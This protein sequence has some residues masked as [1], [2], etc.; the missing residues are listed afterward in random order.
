MQ[1]C[2][3][4]THWGC[5]KHSQNHH[6]QVVFFVGFGIN[7]GEQNMATEISFPLGFVTETGTT[8]LKSA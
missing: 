7:S 6:N 5:M 3:G 4:M 1:M 8:K 2:P